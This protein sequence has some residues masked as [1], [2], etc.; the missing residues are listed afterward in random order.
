MKETKAK[1][2]RC[3]TMWEPIGYSWSGNSTPRLFC[4][5]CIPKIR[6]EEEEEYTI[7]NHIW[8]MIQQSSKYI[9]YR[10]RIKDYY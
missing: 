5:K 10:N 3:E 1:C 7:P 6:E 8:R 4:Q 2:P 9:Q